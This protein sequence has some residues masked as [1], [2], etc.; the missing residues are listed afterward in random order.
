VIEQLHVEAT[1]R[2]MNG[3]LNVGLDEADRPSSPPLSDIPHM[4]ED[5]QGEKA[6]SPAG[7]ERRPI[8]VIL[9][10]TAK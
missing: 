3:E 8:P 9:L 5:Q 2:A 10:R 6:C 1:G 7:H 4:T